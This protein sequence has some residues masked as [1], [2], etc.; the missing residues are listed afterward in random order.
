MKTLLVVLLLAATAHAGI[1]RF[2]GRHSKQAAIAAT[3]LNTEFQRFAARHS[4]RAAKG[5]AHKT[6]HAARRAG[7]MIY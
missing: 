4:A 7:R 5:A 1:I 6:A 3:A 2:S